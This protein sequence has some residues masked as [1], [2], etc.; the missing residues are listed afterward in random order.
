ME[1]KKQ[2][3]V[4]I[5]I[6]LFNRI[7]TLQV[8]FNVIR[9]Q[10][11][12][13]LYIYGDGPRLHVDGEVEKCK[14]ARSIV[15]QIDW[16]CDLKTNFRE[17]N[18]GSAGKGVSSGISWFFENVEQGIIFEHDV[19]PHPDYFRFCEELLEKYKDDER[20]SLINGVNFQNGIKRGDGSYYFSWG[21][22]NWGFA[23]WRRF[24]KHYNLSLDEQH[25]PYKVFLKDMQFYK[26]NWKLR[27][28]RK[29]YFKLLRERK[30]DD[31]TFQIHY[32][33]HKLHGLTIIPNVN[34]ISNIGGGEGAYNLKDPNDCR[35]NRAIY[36]ILPLKHPTKIEH[37]IKADNYQ[38]INTS[39]H[40]VIY[41]GNKSLQFNINL[42][43]VFLLYVC[44]RWFR[45]NF[46]VKPKNIS[47]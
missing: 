31:W 13:H 28:I 45:R 40:P 47:Y 11:P 24:W 22:S 35:L 19:I 10:K 36:P 3:E 15:R 33:L 4:P 23:T 38:T 44:W 1:N 12:K 21:S 9:E 25:Y 32:Y 34:M 17:E 27:L 16:D 42:L 46:I 5:L 37:D 6:I 8:L 26:M 39:F 14:Q 43:P 20:I 2:L 7:D 41:I 29:D 30:I 18:S